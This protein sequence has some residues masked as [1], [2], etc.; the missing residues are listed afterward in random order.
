M[1]D[2]SVSRV[3]CIY[4][5]L[6]TPELDVYTPVKTA[7]KYWSSLNRLKSLVS[8]LLWIWTHANKGEI[9]RVYERRRYATSHLHNVANQRRAT[10]AWCTGGSEAPAEATNQ[11]TI[12]DEAAALVG[13]APF[14]FFTRICQICTSELSLYLSLMLAHSNHHNPS[15]NARCL[16]TANHVFNAP[17][18]AYICSC[19]RFRKLLYVQYCAGNTDRNEKEIY[20]TDV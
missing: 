14:S 2:T 6:S 10:P 1:P 9:E 18:A 13:F 3:Q 4:F 8:R 17:K 16:H 19:L 20:F 15:T 11:D 5:S 12:W 7:R